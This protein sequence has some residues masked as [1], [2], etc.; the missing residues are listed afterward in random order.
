M[1]R[2]HWEQSTDLLSGI[3]Q[4]VKVVVEMVES[5][6]TMDRSTGVESVTSESKSEAVGITT[7]DITGV[8]FIVEVV[9]EVV[10]GWDTRPGEDVT[11][12]ELVEQVEKYFVESTDISE[13]ELVAAL[14][15]A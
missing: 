12:A 6:L 11:G 9:V 7:A 4:G 14:L 15:P 10:A 2:S 8:M 5:K 1:S 13:A 3:V